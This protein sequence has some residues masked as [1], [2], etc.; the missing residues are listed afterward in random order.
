MFINK[1]LLINPSLFINFLDLHFGVSLTFE[2][3]KNRII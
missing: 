1:L 3:I 2:I